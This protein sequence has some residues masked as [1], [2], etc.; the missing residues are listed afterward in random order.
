MTQRIQEA[1]DIFLDAISE[2]TLAKGSCIACAV[3]NLIAAG[4][5]GKIER[6]ISKKG[7]IS[8]GCTVENTHWAMLFTTLIS[9]GKQ[10]REVLD[11]ILTKGLG[12][13]KGDNTRGFAKMGLEEIA[14]TKFTPNELA[15]IEHAFETNTAI[16]LSSYNECTDEAIKKDQIRGLE[17]VVKLM[18]QFEEQGDDIKEVFTSK[19]ELIPIW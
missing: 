4:K 15:A 9:D 12:G 14:S 18:L 16:S 6:E 2:G 19:A 11:Q 1:I 13:V 17:A 3:G 7:I 10:R 8:F 5:G